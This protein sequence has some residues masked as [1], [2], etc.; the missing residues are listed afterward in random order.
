[1]AAVVGTCA[2]NRASDQTALDGLVLLL[3]SSS[4]TPQKKHREMVA[5]MIGAVRPPALNINQ[6]AAEVD[7]ID[8]APGAPRNK[9]GGILKKIIRSPLGKVRRRGSPVGAPPL[10]QPPQ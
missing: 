9:T 8:H 10:P 6:I 7:W 1:M 3:S 2:T 5:A 4:S